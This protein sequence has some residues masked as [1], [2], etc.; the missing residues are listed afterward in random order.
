MIETF[1]AATIF[2][3]LVAGLL[4]LVFSAPWWVSVIVVAAIVWMLDK[5]VNGVTCPDEEG[6]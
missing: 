5:L 1:V 3:V 6:D 2:M 4:L